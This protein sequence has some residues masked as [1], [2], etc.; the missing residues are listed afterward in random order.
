MKRHL[1]V[2]KTYFQR[3]TAY[4]KQIISKH[5]L[6][7]NYFDR[8]ICY[9]NVVETNFFSYVFRKT[10]NL[11]SKFPKIIA[12]KAARET[13]RMFLNENIFVNRIVA[14]VIM[15]VIKNLGTTT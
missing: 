5:P 6:L 9:R 1:C 8:V 11:N 12:L 7:I 13:W 15:F 4:S 14:H 10:S 2:E 3:C